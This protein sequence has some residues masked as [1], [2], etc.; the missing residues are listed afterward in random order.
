M[1]EFTKLKRVSEEVYHANTDV[2]DVG[3]Q[4]IGRL[5]QLSERTKRRRVRFCAH[6]SRGEKV[7]QMF[8]VLPTEA[9]VRPHKHIGKA[10]S[11][12]VLQGE[13]DYV[14]FND[15]GSVADI[16]RMGEY[17]SQFPFYHTIG[18]GKYHTIL[19]RT[20][21]LVFLEITQGPFLEKDTIPAEWSPDGSDLDIAGEYMKTISI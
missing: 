21:W 2:F 13:A 4:D 14:V 3:H 20:K 15:T 12:V 6:R 11:I 17:S 5:I 9:Y 8:I 18:P 1:I 16:V 10:E 7:H 19:I